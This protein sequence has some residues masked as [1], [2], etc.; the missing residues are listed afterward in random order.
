M[1]VKELIEELQKYESEMEVKYLYLDSFGRIIGYEI[2][3]VKM[4]CPDETDN[5]EEFVLIS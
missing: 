1:K 5:F 3:E 2:V 4:W